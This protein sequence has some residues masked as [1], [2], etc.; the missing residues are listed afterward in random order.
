MNPKDLLRYLSK[1]ANRFSRLLDPIL[2]PVSVSSER[3]SP[4][5]SHHS[6]FQRLFPPLPL[7][8]PSLAALQ[9]PTELSSLAECQF[10]T[11]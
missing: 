4:A 3:G 6:L 7:L 10:H 9:A 1:P 11:R 2:L 8:P 5:D